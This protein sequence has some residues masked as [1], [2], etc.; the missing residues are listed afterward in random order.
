MKAVQLSNIFDSSLDF[1]NM[2]L[3]NPPENIQEKFKKLD[4]NKETF[5]AELESFVKEN[6]ERHLPVKV[7]LEEWKLMNSYKTYIHDEKYRD[8]YQNI[9]ESWKTLAESTTIDAEKNP[10]FHSMIYLP[11]KY[12]K[13]G[14]YL[15]LYSVPQSSRIHLLREGQY[16]FYE[17]P[18]FLCSQ[19]FTAQLIIVGLLYT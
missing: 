15:R 11:N 5:E 7:E 2:K 19:C 18:K 3:A 9:N 4:Q 17:I 6:F 12:I 14:T 16:F 1:V 10:T 13:V 8:F